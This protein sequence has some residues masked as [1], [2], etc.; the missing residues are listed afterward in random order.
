MSIDLEKLTKLGEQL[1]WREFHKEIPSAVEPILILPD[2]DRRP[3]VHLFDDM[4]ISMRQLVALGQ[5]LP[6]S[7]LLEY[8]EGVKK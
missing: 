1:R 5:W 4:P 3:Y 8:L 6:L 7:P 2:G